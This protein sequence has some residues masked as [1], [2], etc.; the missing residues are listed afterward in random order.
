MAV[1]LAD[2]TVVFCQ[3][4]MNIKKKTRT[5]TASKITDTFALRAIKEKVESNG[6]SFD[7]L[8]SKLASYEALDKLR[9]TEGLPIIPLKYLEMI[10][11]DNNIRLMDL[12]SPE[13][14]EYVVLTDE[15][16]QVLEKIKALS[17]VRKEK[18]LEVWYNII[19]NYFSVQRNMIE[20]LNPYSMVDRIVMMMNVR[21]T[22]VA[23][24]FEYPDTARK[25]WRLRRKENIVDIP[26]GMA[27]K[28]IIEVCGKLR[29]SLHWALVLYDNI[30][31]YSD[32]GIDDMLFDCYTVT[33]DKNKK[34]FISMLDNLK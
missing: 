22:Q 33:T 31:F 20:P 6:N 25:V 34:I 28:D 13:L 32:N 24:N 7:E 26:D 3:N 14:M 2:N 12:I 4:I 19:L 29:I 15:E 17:P 10:L 27:W 1:S 9:L 11:I 16:Q 5:E 18:M 30:P 21:L 8:S 23:N